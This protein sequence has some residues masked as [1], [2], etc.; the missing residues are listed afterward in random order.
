MALHCIQVDPAVAL[1]RGLLDWLTAGDAVLLLGPA[2]ALARDGN[3]QLTDWLSHEVTLHVLED[4]L[5]LLG[6][7]AVDARVRVTDYAGWVDLAVRHS[8]QLAWV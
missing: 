2:S 3:A 6:I 8:R 1:A 4:E 7:D 5:A